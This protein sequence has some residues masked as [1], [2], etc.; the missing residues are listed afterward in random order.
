MLKKDIMSNFKYNKQ[1]IRSIFIL[2]AS[3]FDMQ[4]LYPR[5]AGVLQV[6]LNYYQN[7]LKIE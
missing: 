6:G 2:Q 3:F 5:V 4:I 1:K 7:N